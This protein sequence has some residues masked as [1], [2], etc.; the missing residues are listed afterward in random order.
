M[1]N[2]EQSHALSDYILAIKRRNKLLIGV[3]VPIFV[4]ALVV[5]MTLPNVYISLARISID[6]EGANVRSL[7]PIQV[8]RYADQYIAELR[9]RV[10]EPDNIRPFA[11]NPENFPESVEELPINQRIGIV[12]GNYYFSLQTQP[13][14]SQSGREV[15]IITGFQF[16]FTS[17]KEEFAQKA[18]RFL[19]ESFMREDR[20]RRTQAASSTTNFLTMQIE[21][22][23]QEVVGYEQQMAQFKIDNACCLPELKDLHLTIIQRTERDIDALQPRLR[24]LEQN[25]QFLVSQIDEI[26]KQA[27]T[28][29]RLTE[30]ENEYVRLVANYGSDHPDVTRLR[31]EI[32]VLRSLGDS[33]DGGTLSQL[34]LELAEVQRRYSDAHPDVIRLKRRIAT[35]EAE[36]SDDPA[37]TSDRILE[38]PRFQQLRAELNG[39]D[40]EISEI[41]TRMPELRQRIRDYEERLTRTP[42]VESEFQAIARKLETARETFDG[43]QRDLVT[44]QQTQALESTDIGARLNLIRTASS[45]SQYGPPRAAIAMLGAFL[46]AAAGLGMTILMEMV[47][48]SIR[49][50]KDIVNVAQIIPIAT[51]PVIQNSVAKAA[52]RRQFVVMLLLSILTVS[53]VAAVYVMRST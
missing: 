52:S 47:D 48:S 49:N 18:A 15:D 26:R 40:T 25:R 45:P 11:E 23:E 8:S 17:S 50:S 4:V 51:I 5:A 34:R 28:T 31:R 32:E 33:S 10:L 53:I 12:Q 30:L 20:A 3:A 6:L 36:G 19:S 1:Q 37:L 2:L 29:N 46:A 21:Q 9:D 22:T 39:V 42:Q 14:V 38:N 44:A 16:G 24:T 13:V 43:L 35:L 27:G 7:E 41:R